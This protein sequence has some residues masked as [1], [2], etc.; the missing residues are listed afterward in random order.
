M[1]TTPILIATSLLLA[2]AARAQ[3]TPPAPR[4]FGTGEL[5]EF[6]KPYDLDGDGKLSAEER[7]AFEKA[8]RE[9]RP[10]HPGRPNP[11][12]TDGD[13]KLSPEEIQAARD[14]VAAKVRETRVKR[15]TELDVSKDGQLSAA[16]LKAIPGITDEM[17]ARMIGHLDKDAS[18]TISLEE[19]LAVL[20]PVAPP[21]PPFP[22]PQP[23][24]EPYP[25]PGIRVMFP[26][27][28]FDLDR[29]GYFSEAEMARIIDAL[30]TDNDGRVS[31]EEWEA[32][33][34][35][36]FLP[37]CPLPQPLPNPFPTTGLLYAPPL[38]PFDLDR[39]LRLSLAEAQ[40]A[41][42]ALDTDKDGKVSPVEWDAYLKSRP[43][44]TGG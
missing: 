36:Q 10:K 34:K 4:P 33:R 42:A 32:Y 7:Q 15:F 12:D 3:T 43:G 19:F 21:I 29:N 22:F 27:S 24:P 30:D 44:G 31:P 2:A 11:W 17:V 23:L 8:V 25:V 16:E 37:P 13:G 26:L 35:T 6:L 18:G 40:A 1:K 9:A 5:P 39:N 28:S 38:A 14:A 20:K 41:I